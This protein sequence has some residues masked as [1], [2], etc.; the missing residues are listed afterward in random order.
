MRVR[1]VNSDRGFEVANGKSV[2]DAA[3]A[4]S[5][6]LPHRCGSGNCGLCKARLVRGEVHY[7]NGRPLGLEHAA[8][9]A[10]QIVLCLAVPRSD[11]VLELRE[12]RTEAERGATRLPCRI[13]HA[14]RVAHD[15]MIV[16]LRLPPAVDFAFKPGQYVDILTEAADRPGHRRRSFSIASSSNEAHLLEL[17]VRRVTGGELTEWLFGNV[18]GSLLTIEGPLGQ[19]H[20]REA[21]AAPAGAAQAGAV[22]GAVL[23]I[24]GGTGIAPLLSIV[25]HL[26]DNDIQRE[27]VLYWGVRGSRDLYAE[28]TIRDLRSRASRMRYVPVLSE[29][30]PDWTG[31]TGLVHSAVLR[32]IADL[33]AFDIYAAGPPAMIEAL[34]AD[35]P[36]HGARLDHVF[37]DSF[38]YARDS[39]ERQRDSAST[40]S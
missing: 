6:R 31:G 26:I 38:D 11:L 17:H 13:E 36:H 32:E 19:F 40:K 28:R 33:G 39:L 8:S 30:E 2:L 7:P 29:P 4:A 12:T 18:Q 22:A 23:L 24:G 21:G 3:L 35:F 5:W 37:C 10:G 20:Y 9:T 27:I 14:S 15:V 25:R 1:V 16:L 34:R